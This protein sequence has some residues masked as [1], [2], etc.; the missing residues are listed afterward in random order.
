MGAASL[1]EEPAGLPGSMSEGSE[2][3]DG[4]GTG[5]RADDEV[6]DDEEGPIVVPPQFP[7]GQPADGRR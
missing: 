6:D 4:P 5:V 2:V 1:T 3:T 7:V